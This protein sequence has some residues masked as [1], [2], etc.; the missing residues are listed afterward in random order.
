VPAGVFAAVPVCV[1]VAVELCPELAGFAAACAVVP[2]CVFVA[3]SLAGFDAGFAVV[4]GFAAGAEP[5]VVVGALAAG[6]FVD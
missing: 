6:G 2:L 1:F 3:E 4:A 5:S